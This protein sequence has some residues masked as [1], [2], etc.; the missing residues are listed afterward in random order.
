M[1]QSQEAVHK[2]GTIAKRAGVSVDTV[3]YYE[4]RG[5][6]SPA[7]RMSS[8]YRLYSD[9]AVLRIS[10]ARRLQSL[11]MT[12]E[13]VA[14]ALHSHDTGGGSCESERWRLEKARS[15]VEQKLAELTAVRDAVDTALNLCAAGNCELTG[16][17]FHDG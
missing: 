12:L 15:R 3:R 9:K 13:E 5:L 4:Q 17:D 16:Q 10:L 8:G 11:G 1:V 7:K 14:D 6:L 2:I